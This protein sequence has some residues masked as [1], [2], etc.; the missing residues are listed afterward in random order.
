MGFNA[1]GTNVGGVQSIEQG[2][3]DIT[4][5]DTTFSAAG[6]ENIDYVVPA[7][8]KWIIKGASSSAGNFSGTSGY[9]HFKIGIGANFVVLQSI[10]AG[11]YISWLSTTPITLVEGQKVRFVINCSMYTSG[12]FHTSILY[13]EINA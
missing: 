12:Q 8:K 9:H 1:G 3:P 4:E 7:G 2:E 11:D 13:Q 10:T 5:I 6:T